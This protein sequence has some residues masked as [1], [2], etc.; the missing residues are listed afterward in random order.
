[1]E[2][3]KGEGGDLFTKK[4]EEKKLMKEKENLKEMKNKLR[5]SIEMG[6]VQK[7]SSNG[8]SLNPEEEKL[9]IKDMKKEVKAKEKKSMQK[10]L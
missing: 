8:V 10:S 4:R 7:A 1:M 6:K 9:K 2:D 5:A 3:N